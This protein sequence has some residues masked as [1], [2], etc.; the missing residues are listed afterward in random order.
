MVD[1]RDAAESLLRPV[2]ALL[3][4][5]AW[6]LAPVAPAAD[7]DPECLR[8]EVRRDGES[9]TLEGRVVLAAVDGGVLVELADQR[10]ELLQPDEIAGREPLDSL[11]LPETPRD[12]GL[13]VLAELPPGFDVL[14]TKHY[15]VCFDTSRD[16][17][18]WCVSLFERL[19]DAFANYWEKA[20][21]ELAAADRPLVVVIFSSRADYEQHAAA[22]LGDAA[23]RV[24][25]YYNLLS[26]RVTT[27]DL[28]GSDALARG[29][30]PPGRAALEALASPEAAGMVS[31]LVHE[32][33]HQMA[34]NSGMHR[35]LAAV[36]L[37]VSEGVATYFETPDLRSQKGWR[38]IGGVNRPRLEQVLGNV[39]NGMLAD[40]VGG[41]DAF[42]NP[43]T[44]LD[45]YARA[46]ALTSFLVATRKDQFVDY[47]R[48]I[49]A[50]PPLAE[51]DAATR[52]AEFEAA[53]GQPPE[54]FE[55]DVL[56][57]LDRLAAKRP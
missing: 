39:R 57:H 10:Y 40:I 23:G 35:R 11:A 41:D 26:N 27:F 50:K 46:W 8:L 44:A 22:D 14:V 6:G 17:A 12:L 28:T 43:D 52:T 18:R 51:D 20:G 29:G 4:A 53:F 30:R 24:V 45:A 3:A 19:H 33:T 9:T 48:T 21:L 13:R 1:R 25:G 31:T 42:R 54:A 38:G 49:A 55:D 32:A 56:R 36:P 5:L 47:L 16:Y 15:V 2:A 34:F 7:D 37:W